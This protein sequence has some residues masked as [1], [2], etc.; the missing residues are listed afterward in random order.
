M[1][2]WVHYLFHYLSWIRNLSLFPTLNFH[3]HVCFD[4]K[5][6]KLPG[7]EKLHK[8]IFHS[9]RNLNFK[10]FNRRK[11]KF[12]FHLELYVKP[13]I[14]SFK[15]RHYHSCQWYCPTLVIC[16]QSILISVYAPM[17]SFICVVMSVS[18]AIV[19]MFLC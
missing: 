13:M 15:Q 18:A 11:S 5:H 1:K 12:P 4:R 9:V 14:W 16:T 2:C 3:I 6:V 7:L 10:Y 19:I 8:N 17:N